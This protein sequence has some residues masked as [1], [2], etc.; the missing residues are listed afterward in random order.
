MNLTENDI[1]GAVLHE[2]L[3]NTTVATT[4]GFSAGTSLPHYIKH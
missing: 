1:P 4:L 2:P 3:E